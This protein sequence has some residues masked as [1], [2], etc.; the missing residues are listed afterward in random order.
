MGKEEEWRIRD[1]LIT[2]WATFKILN[3]YQ[4][5]QGDEEEKRLNHLQHIEPEPQLA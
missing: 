3:K 1:N 5:M 2:S 4:L